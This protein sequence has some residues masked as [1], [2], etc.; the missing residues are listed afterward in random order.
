MP[1]DDAHFAPR[2]RVRHASLSK[3]AFDRVGKSLQIDRAVGHDGDIDPAIGLPYLILDDMRRL[4]HRCRDHQRM[5]LDRR[6]S[7]ILIRA[8]LD[9]RS[10]IPAPG[11][12]GIADQ[13]I[14]QLIADE[15]LRQV[16]EIGHEDPGR[17]AV[18]GKG[19]FSRSTSRQCTCRLRT[20]A[21]IARF[22]PAD[23]P[24]GRRELVDHGYAKSGGD[25]RPIPWP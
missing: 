15:G 14:R 19:R 21:P 8:S 9:L 13:A 20:S 16:V 10:Q 11:Q 12:A 1:G 4:H 17:R 5:D 18:R 6:R 24:L 2:S 3:A 23:Q 7:E 22:A 25:G